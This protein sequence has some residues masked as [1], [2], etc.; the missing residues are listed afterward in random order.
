MSMHQEARRRQMHMD[1]VC[2]AR[3]RIALATK[4]AQYSLAQAAPSGSNMEI[5]TAK[6]ADQRLS[7]QTLNEF[8]QSENLP[9][10]VSL[11]PWKHKVKTELKPYINTCPPLLQDIKRDHIYKVLHPHTEY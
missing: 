7:H 9:T 10:P 5:D 1:R 4:T 8:G 3:R 11:R 6:C 2:E